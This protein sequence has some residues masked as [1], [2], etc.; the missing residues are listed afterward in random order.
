MPTDTLLLLVAVCSV[1]LLFAIVL[2]WI[3]RSTSR[4]LR[5]KAA[6]KHAGESEQPYRKAA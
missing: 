4:W 3:D 1:F 5:A 6:E 2:A